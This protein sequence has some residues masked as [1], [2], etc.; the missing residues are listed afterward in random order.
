MKLSV[1]SQLLYVILNSYSR[2]I[3]PSLSSM[4]EGREEPMKIQ[5]SPKKM[6]I[7]SMTSRL[8]I[9]IENRI[10]GVNDVKNSTSFL[11]H[12]SLVVN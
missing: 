1:S 11:S 5:I 10:N 7:L 2:I 4:H 8:E 9:V 12:L 3:F 6:T